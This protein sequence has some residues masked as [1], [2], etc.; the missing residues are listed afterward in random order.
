M[1]RDLLTAA[2]VVLYEGPAT[3]GRS[4]RGRL[5]DRV[6]GIGEMLWEALD[7]ADWV[8]EVVSIRT[9]VFVACRG[10]GGALG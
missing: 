6:G 5:H 3:L 2:V 10:R 9:T 8:G 1:I 4:A 7:R